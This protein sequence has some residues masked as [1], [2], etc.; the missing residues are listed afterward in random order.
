MALRDFASDV[1]TALDADVALSLTLGTN[2]FIGK[3]RAADIGGVPDACVSVMTIGGPPPQDYCQGGT[4]SPQY[5]QPTL[6]V[7][8]R[9]APRDW[10]GGDAVARA[11]FES[12]ND[13]PPSAYHGARAQTGAPLYVGEDDEGQHLWSIPFTLHIVE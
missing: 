7:M 11:V 2:L 13:S 12:V 10:A 1:A 5:Y 8:V 3:M 4:H 9:S 6:Q